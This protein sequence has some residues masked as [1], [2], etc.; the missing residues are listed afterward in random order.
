MA[1]IYGVTSA[2]GVPV[3]I[4]SN[5]QL[6]TQT[7]SRRYKEEIREMGDAT[8]ALMKLRPVT[9]YYKHEYDNGPRTLQYGLIAEEV[10]KVFPELVAY[11]TDGSPYTVRYQFLS[12]MLLNEVQKQ[13]RRG[14]DQAEVIQ[15]QEQQ[16]NELEE[17]LTRIEKILSSDAA[18]ADSRSVPANLP[19]SLLGKLVL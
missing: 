12:S 18:S 8:A 5:G 14:Q 9:F 19:T 1:G 7:S 4:N 2:S 3:F 15:A 17:R 16:I 6:G 10:A 13:Y 11:N